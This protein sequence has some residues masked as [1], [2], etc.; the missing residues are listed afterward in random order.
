MLLSRRKIIFGLLLVALVTAVATVA[1][2]Y[3]KNRKLKRGKT[4]LGPLSGLVIALV[5][6]A[7]YIY[8]KRDNKRHVRGKHKLNQDI[9]D[10]RLILEK[11]HPNDQDRK[12][13]FDTAA[14]HLVNDHASGNFPNT[15]VW[16]EALRSIVTK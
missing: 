1:Y 4:L 13:A 11:N 8:A 12:S 3:Y 5:A 16:Y 14:R 15:R 7:V 2:F 10:M 6:A 9:N